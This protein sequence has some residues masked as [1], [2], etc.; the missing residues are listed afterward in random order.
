L[1]SL[2]VGVSGDRGLELETLVD[3]VPLHDL[4][5]ESTAIVVNFEYI[6]RIRANIDVLR[7]PLLYWDIRSIKLGPL[8]EVKVSSGSNPENNFGRQRGDQ[9]HSI[10]IVV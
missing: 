8:R 6:L 7:A 9:S 2:V 3:D 5:V 10:L 1:A 4:L